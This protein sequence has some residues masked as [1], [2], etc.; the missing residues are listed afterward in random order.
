M[1]MYMLLKQKLYRHINKMAKRTSVSLLG[2]SLRLWDK[3]A[4][5]PKSHD[6]E[7]SCLHKK[8]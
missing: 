8:E 4:N 2:V 5:V 6:E 1:V 7:G 3:G